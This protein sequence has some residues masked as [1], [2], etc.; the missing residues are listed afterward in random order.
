LGGRLIAGM[1][2]T[3]SPDLGAVLAARY[4][5]QGMGL[6]SGM[7]RGLTDKWNTADYSRLSESEAI[8][9]E[10]LP[11]VVSRRQLDRADTGLHGLA[12]LKMSIRL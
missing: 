5:N 6:V 2:K 11:F 7:L 12:S 4:T 8:R 10:D 3:L 1:E 9:H